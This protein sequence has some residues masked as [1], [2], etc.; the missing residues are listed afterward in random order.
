[1]KRNSIIFLLLISAI[2]LH[3]QSQTDNSSFSN[4][5]SFKAGY[6]GN[7]FWDHGLNLG[8]EYTWNEKV[9]V[10]EKRK[11]QKTIVRQFLLHGNLGYSTNF[12]N[13]TD[14]GLHTYCGLIW[15]RTG[16]KGWQLNAELNPLGYYRSILPETIKVEGDDVSS[17]GL[18]GRG[19]YAPSITLGIGR[20]SGW[21]LNVNYSLRT[22]F[23]SGTLPVFALQFGHRFNFK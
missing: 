13:Q 10:K 22:P 3:A 15:R 4:K 12:T 11:G 18:P 6:Y 2:H 9:K 16:H 19:Y 21:Y 14:E 17:V 8:A 23:N 5:L 20:H 1:M 7:F